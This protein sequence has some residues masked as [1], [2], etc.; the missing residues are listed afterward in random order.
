MTHSPAPQTQTQSDS[1]AVPAANAKEILNL[2]LD[3]GKRMMCCGGEVHR[4]ED[5]V[6][7]VCRALGAVEVETF[8]ITSMI[9]ASVT[10]PD[11]SQDTH[12]RYFKDTTRDLT[13]LERLN[14]ISRAICSGTLTIEQAWAQLDSPGNRT[15]LWVLYLGTVLA[16]GASAVFFGG[17]LRDGIC[18]GLIGILMTLMEQYSPSYINR[19]AQVMLQSLMAGCLALLATA[20]G[21]GSDAGKIMIGTIMLLIPGLAQS[22]SVRELLCGDT[23]SGTMRMI[24]CLVLTVMIAFGYTLAWMLLGRM[25]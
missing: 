15:K 1:A 8:V 22:S 24:Q 6:G 17:T 21:L 18:A 2:A 23:V 9:S 5:L 20:A 11:G 19:M 16:A 25:V 3:M 12:M 10:M 13:E 14:D 4:T 7:R